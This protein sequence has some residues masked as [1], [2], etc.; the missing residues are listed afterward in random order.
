[1]Q[2]KSSE[3]RESV[4]LTALSREVFHNENDREQRE[5]VSDDYRDSRERERGARGADGF[6]ESEGAGEM[7]SARTRAESERER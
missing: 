2:W 6:S 3:P 1:M 7:A 5:E 4:R